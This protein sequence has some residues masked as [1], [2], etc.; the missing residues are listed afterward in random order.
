MSNQTENTQESTQT[1]TQEEVKPLFS[2]TDSQGKERLF[3]D[4]E[5]VQKSWQSSQNFIKDT[6]NEKQNLE[7]KV[8]EL[9]AQLNQSVKLEEA[10]AR[11]Q[12]KEESPVTT[13]QTSNTSEATPQLDEEQLAQK[14]LS[15][16]ESKQSATLQQQAIA[17][18]QEESI[19]A[20]QAVY[21]QDYESKL[22]ER[23]QD[24][25]MSD[26]DIIKQAQSSPKVFKA[27]FGLDKQTSN[28]F[29]PSSSYAKAPANNEKVELEFGGFTESQKMQSHMGNIQALMKKHGVRI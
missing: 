21:G 11:L 20:A 24:L 17:K 16:M 6:V 23:A 18:N 3:T 1:T 10:L 22:R 29:M 15:M 14:I 26:E 27:L 2:G 4:V 25:G 5:D 13:T 7:A 9:E 8:A 19:E 12:T 28:N